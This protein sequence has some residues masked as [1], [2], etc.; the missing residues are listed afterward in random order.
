MRRFLVS[1]ARPVVLSWPVPSSSSYLRAFA[2]S[3][4]QQGSKTS[5]P[6]KEDGDASRRTGDYGP[7]DGDKKPLEQEGQGG[8]GGATGGDVGQ[9]SKSTT[10]GTKQPGGTQPKRSFSTAASNKNTAAQSSSDSS[11][12]HKSAAGRQTSQADAAN[13]TKAGQDPTHH[14]PTPTPA[15]AQQR[16]A[17]GKSAVAGDSATAVHRK[18]EEYTQHRDQATGAE[19][20][21]AAD[22]AAHDPL[23]DKLKHS[24]KVSKE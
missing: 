4:G 12:A 7:A 15:E 20:N 10:S 5:P 8:R 16:K 23:P 13:K 3:G 21:V 18:Q 14:S 1:V 11:T 6:S 9:R 2:T 17:S 24:T 22:R 19:M